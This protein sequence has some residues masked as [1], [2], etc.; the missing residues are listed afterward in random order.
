MNAIDMYGVTAVH[1]AAEN[2]HVDCLYVLLDAGAA[3]NIGT[4]EKRPQWVTTTGIELLSILFCHV[5][6]HLWNKLPPSLRAT[7]EWNKLPPSLRATSECSHHHHFIQ[8]Y[9]RK[10]FYR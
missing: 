1:L 6:P 9:N 3:C 5:A 8:L 10:Y 2:G 4:A 7:S